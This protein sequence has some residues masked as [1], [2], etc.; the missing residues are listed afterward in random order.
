MVA[1]VYGVDENRTIIL[2]YHKKLNMWLPPGGHINDNELPHKAAIREMKEET[3]L[4][5]VLLYK[6]Y[7]LGNEKDKVQIIPAPHHIQVE[8]IADGNHQHIDLVY[9]AKIVSKEIKI[10][11]KE[12]ADIRRYT[13]D[14]LFG[15][16]ITKNVRYFG[17]MAINEVSDLFASI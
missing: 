15:D 13:V 6:P 1:T 17:I 2:I 16:E 9:F 11:H 7:V 14:Q 3:G 4:D 5:V 12:A 8:N 10:N